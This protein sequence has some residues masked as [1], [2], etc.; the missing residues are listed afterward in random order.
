MGLNGYLIFNALKQMLKD[1]NNVCL[2]GNVTIAFSIR[3]YK[4]IYSCFF[5]KN[6]AQRI[7]DCIGSGKYSTYIHLG[8]FDKEGGH[9]NGIVFNWISNFIEIERY[10]PHGSCG[11]LSPFLDQYLKKLFTEDFKKLG[12]N[13]KYFSPLEYCPYFGA[14]AHSNDPVGYCGVFSAMYIFDRLSHPELTRKQV[15]EMYIKT[16]PNVLLKETEDFY[17]LMEKYPTEKENYYD[18]LNLYD[19]RGFFPTEDFLKSK[20]NKFIPIGDEYLVEYYQPIPKEYI[21]DLDESFKLT[22]EIQ[23]QISDPSTDSYHRKKYKKKLEKLNKKIEKTVTTEEST[24]LFKLEY[25]RL[26]DE[27]N[28][29]IKAKNILHKKYIADTEREPK[30]PTV[31]RVVRVLPKVPIL[32]VKQKVFK[33][34]KKAKN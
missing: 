11:D 12:Y 27:Q 14:Q 20:S 4:D 32:P 30:S 8:I 33:A 31:S 17:A 2:L 16:Q 3:V 29:I 6:L 34:K 19:F 13:I 25:Q 5:P 15:A 28:N 26:L 23:K 1:N 22:Q 24:R 10:E 18:N 21:I 7:V 9:A